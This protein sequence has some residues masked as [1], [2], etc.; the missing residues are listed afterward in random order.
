MTPQAYQ[1]DGHLPAWKMLAIELRPHLGGLGLFA[2]ASLIIAILAL[3]MPVLIRIALN[4]AVPEENLSLL[5]WVV[6]GMVGAR[7]LLVGLSYISKDLVIKLV[8]ATIRSYRRTLLS[9]LLNFE[10]AFHTNADPSDLQARIIQDTERVNGLLNAIVTQLL[11]AI[12]ICVTVGTFAIYLEW[13]LVLV[14]ALLAPIIFLIN[15][16]TGKRVQRTFQDFQSS[17]DD[18]CKASFFF[19]RNIDLIRIQGADTFELDRQSDVLKDLSEKTHAKNMAQIVHGLCFSLIAVLVIALIVLGGGLS[20]INGGRT[21]GD[22]ISFFAALQVLQGAVGTILGAIPFILTGNESLKRLYTLSQSGKAHAYN[23]TQSVTITSHFEFEN[24]SFAYGSKRVL[25]NVSLSLP[26]QGVSLIVGQNGSGKSTLLN[27]LLGLERP[28]DGI[29]YCNTTAYDDIDVASLRR[30][31]GVVPQNPTLFPGTLRDNICYGTPNT[32]EDAIQ[33]AVILA[34]LNT[35]IDGL[36]AGINSDI[37]EQGVLLSGGQRQRVAIARALLQKPKYL[38]FDEPT[39]HLDTDAIDRIFSSILTMQDAPGM[40]LISHDQL[41]T[42]FADRIFRVKS[43]QV[44]DDT[45]SVPPLQ[46]LHDPAGS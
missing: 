40:L 46:K 1:N 22:L 34:E 25:E 20:V 21:I 7:L 41:V 29:V 2:I 32:S 16:S 18:F 24:V 23:G 11:P 30:Q 3:S 12:L 35:I 5:G 14:V 39:N 44:F 6:G 38:V 31:I 8:E 17:F 37:G 15:R 28:T 27:L 19:L 9:K 10:R 33:Q 45:I 26:V 36:P 43:G 13:R 42:H 4:V